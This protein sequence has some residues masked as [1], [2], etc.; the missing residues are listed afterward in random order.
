MIDYVEGTSGKAKEGR[1]GQ[2]LKQDHI[3]EEE[4]LGRLKEGMCVLGK[5]RRSLDVNHDVSNPRKSTHTY[6]KVC[7]LHCCCQCYA[8]FKANPPA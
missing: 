5:H 4:G 1:H 6:I 3:L 8:S 2:G 7:L